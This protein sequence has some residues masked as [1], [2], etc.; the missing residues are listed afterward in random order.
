MILTLLLHVLIR[1]LLSWL[2]SSRSVFQSLSFFGKDSTLT[3]QGEPL[4]TPFPKMERRNSLFSSSLMLIPRRQ[5]KYSGPPPSVVSKTFKPM[6]FFW[7]FSAK[8]S[9]V[10]LKTTEM[11]LFDSEVTVATTKRGG[12]AG[13]CACHT[14]CE[15]LGHAIRERDAQ[16]IGNLLCKLRVRSARD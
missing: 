14:V 16:V 11:V 7:K 8:G 13:G 1:T 3:R 4:S 9:K 12:Q 6:S 15:A 10:P 5:R 2:I